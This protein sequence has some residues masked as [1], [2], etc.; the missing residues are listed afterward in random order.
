MVQGL[1]M[2]GGVVSVMA[3]ICNWDWYF[4]TRNAKQI[5]NN[6]GRKRARIFYAVLGIILIGTAIFFF[7]ET[8]AILNK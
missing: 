7:V 8:R 5:V 6:V 1:F 2:L 3:A 4:D